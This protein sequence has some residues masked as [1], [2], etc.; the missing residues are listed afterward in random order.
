[1]INPLRVTG[2]T[3][4]DADTDQPIGPLT[5]GL[6]LDLSTLP[7]RRLNVRAETVPAAVGSVRLGLDAKAN[8]RTEGAAPYA[9]AGDDGGDYRAWTPAAGTHTLTATAYT[10][11]NATG[12]A[13]LPLVVR[14][15]VR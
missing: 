14:F 11:P 13:S 5:D 9:L 2:L 3:L 15:T 4:I 8:Y 10:G 1:V 7:T 6:A 12:A